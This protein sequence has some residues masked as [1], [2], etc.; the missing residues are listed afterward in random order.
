LDRLFQKGR[1][2]DAEQRRRFL[3]RLR[4]EIRKLCVVRTFFDIEKL[5]GAANKVERVLGEMGETPFEPLQEEQEGGMTGMSMKNLT[6]ALI[7]FL[8]GSMPNPMSSFPPALLI[9]CQVYEG[10][11]HIARTCPRLI[12]P[13]PKCARC[14]GP[15]KIESC[16][17]RYPF[18]SDLGRA[19]GRYQRKQHEIGSRFGAANFL[20]A[21]STDGET[22]ATVKDRVAERQPVD[23]FVKMTEV[24]NVVTGKK[25]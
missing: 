22:V 20:G 19:E 12:S 16:G 2:T 17:V 18:D 5:V 4:P 14:G 3:A 24:T 25:W 21:L 1:I 7:N 10:R 23:E 15:H 9:E 6:A 11:D 13:W 8:E